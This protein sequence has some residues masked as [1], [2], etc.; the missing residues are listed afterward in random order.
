LIIPLLAHTKRLM[1][2]TLLLCA[3]LQLVLAG[4]LRA[5]SNL[6][7]TDVGLHGYI[8]ASTSAVRLIVVNPSL[9]PQL[10]HLRI[11]AGNKNVERNAITT[12]VNLG[13]GEQRELELPIL[14]SVGDIA[15]KADASAAGA[16]IGHDSYQGATRQF[17]MVF[18]MC[19]GED[20]CRNAQSQIQ[21]SGT[22]EERVDKNRQLAFEMLNEPRDYWWAYSAATTIV[23]G[24]PTAAF[25]SAQREALEGFLLRGGRLIL[26]EHE[27]ADPGFLSAYR[28]GP[29]THHDEIVGLGN[30]V[31]VTEP[32][33]DALGEAF[34]PARR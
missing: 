11:S 15:I 1:M 23:L 19:A 7:I 2:T 5:D 18:L 30:L 27:I 16:I 13:G 24:M 8:G 26:L 25:S 4:S 20:V 12:D 9:Q 10:I 22:M 28:K 21:F 31:R 32:G 14:L 6:H 33:T 3:G 34:V 17:N 29:P